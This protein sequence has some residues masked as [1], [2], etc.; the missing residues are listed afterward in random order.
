[1][2]SAE[3]LASIEESLDV[4]GTPGALEAIREGRADAE[5]GRFVDNEE[6]KARYGRGVSRS[7]RVR[8][9][10]RSARDLQ[11][12]PDK[13]ATACVE[14]IFGPLAGNPQRVGRPL[15]AELDGS[16]SAR[17]GDYRV[18][19]AIRE[20]QHCVDVEHIDRRSDMYR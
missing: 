8:I 2:I 12:L 1:M 18:V 20:S 17:R 16:H 15:R 5:A 9:T 3:D 11:R 13:I 7:Y 4:L 19:Y 14:F 10:A 6:I